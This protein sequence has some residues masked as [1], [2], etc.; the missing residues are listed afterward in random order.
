MLK[1]LGFKQR[2]TLLLSIL[3][4]SSVGLFIKYTY[5][6]HYSDGNYVGAKPIHDPSL[7]IIHKNGKE[8]IHGGNGPTEEDFDISEFEL[9]PGQLHYGIGR[10]YFP[11]L[12]KPE[13]LSA[14]DANTWLGDDEA[15][16]AAR[17]NDDIKVYPIKLLYQHEI[18]NDV[19]DGKPVFAAYCY[20]ANLG[21]MYDRDYNGT[22][23]TFG[24]SGY[25]YFDPEIW[26][27]RDAFVFWDRETESLW[28][29]PI[30]K[31]V[32]GPL[33]GVQLKLLEPT[34]WS[35]TT[36]GKVKEKYPHALVLKNGQGLD[37]PK[38]WESLNE[39]SI[40]SIHNGNETAATIAP[41]WGKNAAIGIGI[42]P[43][44]PESAS[45]GSMTFR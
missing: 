9:N 44:V 8:W 41:P 13:F 2:I 43:D 4:L 22:T 10:E 27:G 18:V 15:V 1:R 33:N 30:G 38:E 19:I 28:W 37:R 32:S 6:F 23:L 12:I 11:A 26:E 5:V 7:L 35:Q 42:E 14:E 16:L 25:T 24:L 17:V 21:A 34:L 29:P 3:L 36:W 45:A 39:E 31:A 40:A 20:L